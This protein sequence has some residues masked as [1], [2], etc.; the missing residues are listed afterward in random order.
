MSNT[1]NIAYQGNVN[2]KLVIGGKIINI[3]SH[4]EGTDFLKKSICKF[5]S[6]NYGGEADTPQ[7]LD[8]R[9]YDAE[10]E[11]WITCLNQE[12]LL[13]GKKYLLTND[14]AL[15]ITNNWVAR[16]TSAIPNDALRHTNFSS[17]VQYRLYLVSGFDKDNPDASHR[18][19][20]M[21]Y[22]QISYEALNRI[23]PGTQALVEWN[24]QIL[25]ID[26]VPIPET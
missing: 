25:N 18:Y 2:V 17:N 11:K 14:D 5:L 6:G 19:N 1:M 22:V 20:D 9:E 24:M 10:A 26:E 23:T 3:E 4:N 7:S 15:G 13:T 8:L 16:F 12:I 21:A